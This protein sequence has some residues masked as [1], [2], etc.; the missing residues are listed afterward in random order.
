MGMLNRM[1]PNLRERIHKV[2]DWRIAFAQLEVLRM[3]FPW[4]LRDAGRPLTETPLY[5]PW[6]FPVKS[7]LP[8]HPTSCH[9]FRD[10]WNHCYSYIRSDLEKVR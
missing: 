4:T 5:D 1:S 9:R 8:E 6:L 7:Q 3:V 10:R 2:L